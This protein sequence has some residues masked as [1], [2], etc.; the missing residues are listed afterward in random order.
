MIRPLLILLLASATTGASA[1]S[2][3][4]QNPNYAVSRDKY[5]KMSDSI[6]RW[7]STTAQNTYKAYDW[8]EAREERRT[9]RRDNRNAVRLARAQRS[10]YYDSRYNNYNNYNS[11]DPYYYNSRQRGYRNRWR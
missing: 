8:Y 2:V 3:A 9:A 11:Y 6:T 5:M 10:G 7:Q 4:D 1:Q